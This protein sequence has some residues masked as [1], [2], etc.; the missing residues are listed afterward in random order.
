MLNL[1]KAWSDDRYC[2]MSVADRERWDERYARYLSGEKEPAFKTDELL[3]NH[4]ALFQGDGDALDVATGLG[5]N[6]LW[7]SEQGYRT[8]AVDCS[9]NGLSLLSAEAARR[10][11]AVDTQIVDLDDWQ[12][13]G[14]AFD[15]L[16]VFR[17]LNRNLFDAMNDSLRPGG[18]LV[19]QT[20]NTNFLID[21]PGFN[22]EYVLADNELNESFANFEVVVNDQTGSTTRYIGRKT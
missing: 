12:W 7:L 1:S 3:L 13:P 2:S 21:K 6:A 18:L 11:V 10:N 16:C 17:F 4:G 5:G 15:V 9:A 22:A 14:Q 19:Y 20:F 8:T